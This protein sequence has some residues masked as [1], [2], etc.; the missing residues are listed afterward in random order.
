MLDQAPNPTENLKKRH[1]D[2]KPSFMDIP[3]PALREMQRAHADGA[4]KYGALN[5]RNDPVD[6]KTYINAAV[7]HLLDFAEGQNRAPD[8]GVHHLAHVAACCNIVMD[9]QIRG[10]VIDNRNLVEVMVADG[11]GEERNRREERKVAP[12]FTRDAVADCTW[13]P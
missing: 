4:A 8:S 6:I 1:G 12:N 10:E 3:I 9:S 2:L 13:A 11:E 5:W 7:R